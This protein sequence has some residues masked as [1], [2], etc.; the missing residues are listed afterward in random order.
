MI[1]VKMA[2]DW[3]TVSVLEASNYQMQMP[4]LASPDVVTW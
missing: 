1:I 2:P 3:H 4:V